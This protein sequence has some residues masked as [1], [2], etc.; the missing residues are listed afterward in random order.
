MRSRLVQPSFV[1]APFWRQAVPVAELALAGGQSAA[2][3][4]EAGAGVGG[5]AGGHGAGATGWHEWRRRARLRQRRYGRPQRGCRAW[6]GQCKRDGLHPTKQL[7][8]IGRS[9]V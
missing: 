4:P 1:A 8:S 6:L 9:V 5:G 2:A 3:E 7:Q